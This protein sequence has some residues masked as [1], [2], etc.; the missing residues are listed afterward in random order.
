[1]TVQATMGFDRTGKLPTPPD[2]QSP[3]LPAAEAPPAP[4]R[5]VARPAAAKSP[6]RVRRWRGWLSP[7]TRRILALN[8]LTLLIP[9]TGMLYLDQ[10]RAGLVQ[11]ELAALLT[12]AELF[13]GALAASGVVG[14]TPV[15][16]KLLPEMSENTVRRMV[17]VSKNRARLFNDKGELMID[18]F[19]I[20]SAGGQ[21]EREVLPP[22]RSVFEQLVTDGYAWLGGLLPRW[23]S[24]PIYY[25]AAQ[26]HATDYPEVV[27]ALNGETGTAV[28][29][30]RDGGLVMSVAVPVQRYRKVLG[31]LFL[32]TGGQKVE[33]AIR[34]VRLDVLRIFG[35]ALAVTTLLSLYLAGTIA[36][37]IWRLAEAADRVRRKARVGH[38]PPA[39]IPDFTRRNDELGDLSGALRDMT[40]AL[41]QRIDAIERFAADVAHEIKNPLS[42]LRSAVETATRV[43]DPQQQRRLMA[44]V[45]DD[46]QRLDRLISDISDASRLDAELSRSV[47]EP[48]DMGLMLH[49]LVEVHEATAKPEAPRLTLALSD[50]QDLR[51]H[52]VETR[53]VQ[54]MRN[55]ISNAV[56]FSPPGGVIQLAAAREEGMVRIT[57]SDAGP[58]IPAGKL[59]AVF[60]RFYSERPAAEK[61]GTHS[62]LG[63]SISRQI[64]EMHGGTIAAA[65]LQEPDGR[66]TGACFTVRLPAEPDRPQAGRR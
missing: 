66:T 64:V 62:G 55:L 21:V 63:L 17:S 58:G 39:A 24:M 25:E 52:G 22:L 5:K 11:A 37:P 48:V 19:R 40:D 41:A 6:G 26:Q 59:E 14:G 46:V 32:S 57:V 44:I 54:V 18:S 3:A 23:D 28:R 1:M 43:E 16:E 53:L 36:R 33:A 60:D 4:S 34:A 49:T 65:N 42:S 38:G 29:H 9:V 20:V 35:I 51:V 50:H 13:S 61:F 7:L 27:R 47:M 45:L 12:E 30:N 56:S 2:A 15:E 31:A 8:V 10:Y